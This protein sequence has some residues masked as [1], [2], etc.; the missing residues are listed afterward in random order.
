MFML[1]A[2][3]LTSLPEAGERH[4]Y[5]ATSKTFQTKEQGGDSKAEGSYR[6]SN[7][8]DPVKDKQIFTTYKADGM[9]EKI[10]SHTLDVFKKVVDKGEKWE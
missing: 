5:A 9:A 1:M 3:F 2:P 7:N 8:N 4:L 6:L 10:W